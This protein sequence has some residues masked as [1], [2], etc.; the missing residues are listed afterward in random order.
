MANGVVD[1]ARQ[2]EDHADDSQQVRAVLRGETA[3]LMAGRVAGG[4]VEENLHHTGQA[5]DAEAHHGHAGELAGVASEAV[6]CLYQQH[7]LVIQRAPI[8]VKSIGDS[9][10]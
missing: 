4:Q 5:D 2:G 8:G 9:R 1:D 7:A 3:V 6:A 10:W